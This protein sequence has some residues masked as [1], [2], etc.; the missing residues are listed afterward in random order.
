M[1][2]R[3][4]GNHISIPIAGSSRCHVVET[5][6]AYQ[7]PQC[8]QFTLEGTWVYGSWCN[9]HQTEAFLCYHAA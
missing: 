1:A 5:W 2:L 6:A 8:C 9:L 4:Y 3:F 7:Q